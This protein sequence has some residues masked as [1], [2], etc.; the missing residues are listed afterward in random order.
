[1]TW[2]ETTQGIITL[3]ASGVALLG[4]ILT[5]CVNLYNALKEVVKNKEWNKII[6]LA[7]AAMTA[8]EKSDKSGADKKQMVIEAVQAGCKE[9][10][11]SVDLCK[12][13]EYIDE[14]I[15]FANKINKK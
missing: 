1:M 11:I 7:D 9:L 8:A 2:L 4:T 15:D 6:K 10:G 14:C 13:S 5:L 12:L 3:I